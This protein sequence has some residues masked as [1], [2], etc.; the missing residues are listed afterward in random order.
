MK[1]NPKKGTRV[2]WDTSQGKTTGK[3]LRKL[4]T[5]TKIKG[6]TAKP[7]KEEP[8]YLVRSDKSGK[9]AAHKPSELK[10]K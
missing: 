10:K 6:H 8:Q 9:T 5:K 4:T 2:T 7:S 1:T 3:V